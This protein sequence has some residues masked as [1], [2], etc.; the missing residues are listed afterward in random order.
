MSLSTTFR[1]A[2]PLTFAGSSAPRSSRCEAADRMMSCV[3][4]SLAIGN[5]PL[6]WCGVVCRHHHSPASAMQPAGQDPRGTPR[7]RNGHSTALFT[8]ECQSFLD[9]VIAGL[10]QIGAWNEFGGYDQAIRRS[11]II[12]VRLAVTAPWFGPSASA[13]RARVAL[14]SRLAARPADLV[15]RSGAGSC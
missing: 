9:N 7:A 15:V 4:V 10:G 5:P 1:A 8:D 14:P 6:G 12:N 11:L 13:G 2:S 3:S